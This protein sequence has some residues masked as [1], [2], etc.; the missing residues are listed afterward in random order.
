MNIR[1]INII[2][3]I[4]L[5]LGAAVAARA[6]VPHRNFGKAPTQAELERMIPTSFGQWTYEPQVRLVE[7]P[8]SDTLSKQIYNSELARGYRDP[9]GRLVM[10][11]VAY[12][13]SQSDR[14]QLHRP[15]IC[16]AA[17]GFRVERL[18]TVSLD[19]GAGLPNLP[20]RHMLAERENRQEPITYWMRL[21]DTVATNPVERQVLRVEYGLRGYITDGALVR[22]S[23]V[24][25]PEEQ[26]YELQKRF[27]RDFLLSVDDETRRFLIGD[28]NQAVKIG[29]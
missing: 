10:F 6:M 15:E 12:G 3:A 22:L 19:L 24:G 21:G 29:L 9:E 7:P 14:L 5:I 16:Y 27:L 25:L 18:T 11:L 17:Q 26:A 23:T 4:A 28:P 2:V 13:A 1:R 20:V 8:G